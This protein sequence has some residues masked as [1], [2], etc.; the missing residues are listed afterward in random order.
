MA[1]RSPEMEITKVVLMHFPQVFEA[2]QAY[3]PAEAIQLFGGLQQELS[4]CMPTTAHSIIIITNF[5][6][7]TTFLIITQ[8]AYLGSQFVV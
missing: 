2:M 1:G 6:I 8:Q 3:F 5:N 4:G 7:N